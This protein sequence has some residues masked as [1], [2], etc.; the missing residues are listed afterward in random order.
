MKFLKN[1]QVP[2]ALKKINEIEFKSDYIGFNGRLEKDGNPYI[3][4]SKPEDCIEGQKD[5]NSFVGFKKAFVVADYP[6]SGEFVF[7]I[8]STKRSGFTKKQLCE[9]IVE[10]YNFIYDTED[11]TSKK[12]ATPIEKR[13]GLLNRDFTEGMFGI[14]GHDLGDLCLGGIDVYKDSQNDIY[15]KLGIDS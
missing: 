11:D 7:E 12:K 10:I 2:K 6:L 1:K 4:L 15:I 5:K 13:K 9:E 3:Y 14:W 8:V